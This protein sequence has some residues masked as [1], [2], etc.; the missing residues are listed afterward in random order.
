MQVQL[1]LLLC[2]GPCSS[3]CAGLVALLLLLLWG[4]LL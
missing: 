2:Q 4:L 1:L 3:S